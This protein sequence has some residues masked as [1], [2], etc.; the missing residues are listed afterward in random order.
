MASRL[1]SYNKSKRAVWNNYKLDH[2]FTT[3]LGA[4]RRAIVRRTYK[5]TSKTAL[6]TMGFPIDWDHWFLWK[7]AKKTRISQ[8]IIRNAADKDGRNLFFLNSSSKVFKNSNKQFVVGDVEGWYHKTFIL[9]DGKIKQEKNCGL[10]S[11]LKNDFVD[12]VWTR[13]LI[14]Q[15]YILS[16][17]MWISIGLL[18]LPKKGKISWLM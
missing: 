17:G 12:S 10:M 11:E 15:I 1:W 6:A 9:A 4:R 3:S 14:N 13:I 7:E 8:L 16:L 5:T 2:P 18:I